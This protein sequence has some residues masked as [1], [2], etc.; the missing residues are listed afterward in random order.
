MLLI[1]VYLDGHK[2][3]QGQLQ[4]RKTFFKHE[5]ANEEIGSVNISNAISTGKYYTIGKWKI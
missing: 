4:Y 3:K 5:I 1:L 2:L